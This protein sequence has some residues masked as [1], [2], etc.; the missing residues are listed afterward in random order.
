MKKIVFTIIMVSILVS[1]VACLETT[2]STEVGELAFEEPYSPT[3]SPMPD[4]LVLWLNEPVC[5]PPCWENIIPGTTS[6]VDAQIIAPKISG[7]EIEL[8][9]VEFIRLNAKQQHGVINIVNIVSH[10]EQSI[11]VISLDTTN[12]FLELG[13]IVD[14][15]GFPDEI[16]K[17]SIY[18][19][20]FNS[21]SIDLLYYDLGMVISFPFDTSNNINL[22]PH[23]KVDAINFYTPH[24]ENYF[25]HL[26]YGVDVSPA[27]K[28]NGYGVYEIP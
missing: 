7:F 6:F 4:W 9:G 16:L 20:E 18:S 27:I 8:V 19:M 28:L 25:D 3:L 26:Q 15:Y 21:F 17:Y 14:I 24:L 5:Q 2:P 12:T 13:E 10:G 22:N 11:Q 1:L 23:I